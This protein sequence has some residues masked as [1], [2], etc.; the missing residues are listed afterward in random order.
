MK[1]AKCGAELKVGC[2]YCSVCGAEAQI[3]SDYNLLEDDF[4]KALLK[5]KKQSIKKAKQE[6]TAGKKKGK[7]SHPP[8]QKTGR[9]SKKPVWAF[10]MV[11]VLMI[12]LVGIGLIVNYAQNHSYEYQMK[13]AEDYQ[14]K[15]D[16]DRARKHLQRALELDSSSEDAKLLLAEVYLLQKEEDDALK[17]LQEIIEKNK[18]N[19]K[20]Y[21]YFI[22][23]Y[24][25]RKDFESLEKFSREITED[26]IM[27]LFEEYQAKPPLF[28]TKGGTYEEEMQVEL[29]SQ[30]NCSI[31]YT[32]DG[33]DPRNGREYREPIPLEPGKSIRIRAVSCNKYGVYG[34]EAEERFFVKLQKPDMPVVMPGGGSFYSP[35]TITVNVPEGCRVYYTWDGTEPTQESDQYAGPISMPEGNN[36]L[37]LIL[38]DRYGMVSDILKCNYIYIP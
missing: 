18:K 2:V 31:Y 35:Q 15:K 22:Q 3:V 25:D 21:E 26:T 13:K 19:Q 20:A 34:E 38:V 5:D 8:K 9:K 17:L 11:A 12:L 24:A 4:L 27:G 1:C 7:Q 14:G 37:S 32:A 33:S 16:Y 29:L 28:Q 23:I 36:I 30:G 10:V 6:R